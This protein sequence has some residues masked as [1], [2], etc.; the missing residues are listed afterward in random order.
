[1]DMDLS[2]Q[3][4]DCLIEILDAAVRDRQCQLRH[5]GGSGVERYLERQIGLMENVK[6]KLLPLEVT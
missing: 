4:R 2:E 6:S 5:I 1:M 3:E